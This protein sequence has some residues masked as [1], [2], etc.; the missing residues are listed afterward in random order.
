MDCGEGWVAS[1]MMFPE[2]RRLYDLPM[3]AR[4]RSAQKKAHA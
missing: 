2:I 3:L 1:V 4:L